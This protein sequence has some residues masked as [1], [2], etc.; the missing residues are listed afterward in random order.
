MSLVSVP[1]LLCVLVL[2]FLG[3]YSDSAIAA[4]V[5]LKGIKNDKILENVNAH[6]DSVEPPSSPFQ[7]EQYQQQLIDKVNLA[8]QVFGYYHTN[9]TVTGP[10]ETLKNEKWQITADLGQV[11]TI[12]ELIIQLEGEAQDNPAMQAL[13]AKLPLKKGQALQHAA[14]ESSKSQ[15]Q[16]LAFALGYFDFSFNEHSIKIFESR[17]AA[18]VVLKMHSGKRYHFGELRFVEDARAES[19]VRKTLPFKV[20]EPYEADKLALLNKRLKQTQYFKNALVRPLVAEA[21]DHAVPIE[22]ILTHKPQDNFDLGAGFSSDIGPRFTAKWQRPWVNSKGHALSA[23]LF[24]SEPENSISLD[25]RIPIEDPVQNYA[26]L[27]VGFQSQN[28]NDTRSDRFTLSATRHWTVIDSEW[29]RAAFV[30]LEQETFTQGLE[31]EQTTGLLIPGFT[32]SRLRTQGGLDIYWGDK[33]TITIEAAADAL[34]SDINMLRVTAQSKWLRSW[35]LHRLLWR[36]DLGG[37]ATESFEQVPSSLRY[38]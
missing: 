20:G 11:T 26:S 12:D 30:R 14:Y 13:L 19:L 18:T 35:D 21:F 10:S 7:F 16:N 28:D 24:L 38:F 22:V 37:V 1:S 17:F 25:Y 3:A 15:M 33:Q 2:V 34:L 23:E 29:Q 5:E 9:I 27:Q 36:V 6:L 8:V 31:A 4:K 32:L